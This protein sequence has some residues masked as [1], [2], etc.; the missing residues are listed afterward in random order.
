M[1]GQFTMEIPDYSCLNY[2]GLKYEPANQTE[3][4]FQTFYYQT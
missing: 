4:V 3:Y 2:H 1:E